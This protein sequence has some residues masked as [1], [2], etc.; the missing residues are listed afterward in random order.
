MDIT[1]RIKKGIEGLYR[2]GGEVHIS[3]KL[4]HPRV[5]V[6]SSP[7]RIVGVYRNIFQIEERG[8]GKPPAR[9][10]FQYGDILIGWVKIKELDFEPCADIPEGEKSK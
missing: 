8:A 4:S 9:H 10:T 1:D 3:L 6:D 7:A 5:S 2:A